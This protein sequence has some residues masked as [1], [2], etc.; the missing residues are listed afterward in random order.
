[1]NEI[2]YALGPN[3]SPIEYSG[4][5][6]PPEGATVLTE[7]EALALKSE[8]EAADQLASDEVNKKRND[9]LAGAFDSLTNG[10]AMTAEEARALG[11]R[12]SVGK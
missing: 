9:L 11:A 6:R 2:T 10:L 3:G 1:M 4:A 12:P 7:A 5:A 8:I